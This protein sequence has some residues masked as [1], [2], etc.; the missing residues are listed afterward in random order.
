[1]GGVLTSHIRQFVGG[2]D[3]GASYCVPQ[4]TQIARSPLSKSIVRYVV[5]DD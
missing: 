1:M 2:E 3:S 5:V 4:V